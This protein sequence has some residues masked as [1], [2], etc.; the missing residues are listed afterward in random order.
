MISLTDDLMK[1]TRL[2]APAKRCRA[3]RFLFIRSGFTK[4]ASENVRQPN[5]IVCCL[6]VALVTNLSKRGMTRA[7]RDCCRVVGGISQ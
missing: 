4:Y 6:S 7:V 3:N 5:S 2:I 1:I